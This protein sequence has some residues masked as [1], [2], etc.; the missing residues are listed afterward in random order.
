MGS[1]GMIDPGTGGTIDPGTGGAGTG[2]APMDVAPDLPVAQDL[3]SEE[4]APPPAPFVCNHVMGGA[5][6]GQW[7]P[8]FEA[9]M[10]TTHWQAVSA[11]GA[12]IETW[13]TANSGQWSTGITS[14][15]ANGV[16][17]DRVLLIVYSS[18]LT[19]QTQ[20]EN[21]IKMA[22]TNIKTKYAGVK[23]IELL[24]TLRTPDNK[25]C[26]NNNASLTVVPPYVDQA[27]QAVA[28][29]SLPAGMVT[30]G[31][32]IA[33]PSCTSWDTTQG[34]SSDLTPASAPAVG[35]LYVDYYKDHLTP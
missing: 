8:S 18:M 5:V 15:C 9:K 21:S 23:H 7:F 1:G 3:R 27:I 35:Q 32:K 19:T 26:A 11:L 24:A 12:S 4:A 17:P 25:L 31:P 14:A 13:A 28:D 20:F 33:V 30:V 10:D 22:I 29:Q 34:P 2:G 16:R 6:L